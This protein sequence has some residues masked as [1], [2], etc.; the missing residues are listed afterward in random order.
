MV[1]KNLPLTSDKITFGSNK[2][3]WWKGSCGHEWQ[4]SVKARSGGEKCPICSG[5]RVVAGINDL[6]TLE[7]LLVKQW[8]KK[9]KIKPT[10][11]SIGS[12]KKVIW[13]CEKGHEWIATVKSRTINKTGCPYCS[14]NKVLAGFN[15]L[16]TLFPEVADEWSIR[17]KRNQ[18]KSRRL[19]TARLG[20][21]VKSVATNGIR[22]FPHAQ[23]AVNVLVAVDIHL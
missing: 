9:N 20:G 19:Q 22:L 6:A 11:V 21:N 8:S 18:Q 4:A 7:P 13:R 17:M 1:D 14:H 12:H 3:V 15:D 16:A 5:A 23:A 10:E 2:R